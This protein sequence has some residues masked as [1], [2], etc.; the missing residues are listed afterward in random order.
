MTEA[1]DLSEKLIAIVLA[2]VTKDDAALPV[3]PDAA[4]RAVQLIKDPNS[5]ARQVAAAIERDPLL[6]AQILRAASSAAYGGVAVHSLEQAVTRI[7]MQRLRG[8]VMSAVAFGLFD[9][10][11]PRIRD[12]T[13]GLWEHSIAVGILARDLVSLAGE[14]DPEEAYL[15]GLL[16]DVGKQLVGGFLLAAEKQIKQMKNRR[17]IEPEVWLATVQATHR[18]A[19]VALAEKWKLADA[20]VACIRDCDE[21]DSEDRMGIANFIRLANAVVKLEGIRVGPIDEDDVRAQVF[22]GRSLLDIDEEVVRRVTSSLR[23]RMRG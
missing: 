12:M 4:T 13:K 18:K 11:D 1:G 22:I 8:L 14:G 9:S 2:R 17:W 3:L 16:H 6:T 19:A 21:Y 20:V 23:E 10:S 5:T 7:G 15:G